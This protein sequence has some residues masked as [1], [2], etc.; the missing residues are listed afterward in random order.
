MKKKVNKKGDS[1]IPV[2]IRGFIIAIICFIVILIFLFV[3]NLGK[4]SEDVVCYNSVVERSTGGPIIQGGIQTLIPLNCKT[5][6]PCITQDGSCEEM[7]KPEIVKV[8]NV[9][10]V[11]NSLA[12][13]MVTCWSKFGEGKLNYAGRDPDQKLYCSICDQVGFDNSL[14]KVFKNGQINKENFYN[15]MAHNNIS[16]KD[17]TY[18]DYLFGLDNT[19]QIKEV[20]NGNV[21]NNTDGSLTDSKAQIQFGTIT[22]GKQYYVV[23]G[24]FS[25]VALWRKALGTGVGGAAIVLGSIIL[26]AASAGATLPT[27]P[28][29]IAVAA[30]AAAGTAGGYMIGVAE[31]KESGKNYLIPTIIEANSEDFSKLNCSE[32]PT[33][34]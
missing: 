14:N 20:L 12:E 34:A 33:I 25:D 19:Q 31:Q 26:T 27:V 16:G 22:I 11:Y 29:A 23:M 10:E 13:E 32:I 17:V 18:L 8:N 5:H 30:G 28:L 1:N 2:V 15:Y 9:D 7:T 3:L 24:I 6:Y 4:T 21:L